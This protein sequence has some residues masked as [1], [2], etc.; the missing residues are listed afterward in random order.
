MS[1]I[2]TERDRHEQVV[3]AER[4]GTDTLTAA[5]RIA[6]ARIAAKSDPNLF[7]LPSK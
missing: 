3:L 6:E 7:W 1:G 2:F 5:D 4:E